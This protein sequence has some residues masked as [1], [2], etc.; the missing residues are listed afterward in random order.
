L[1]FESIR[2]PQEKISPHVSRITAILLDRLSDS[3]QKIADSAELSILSM[4]SSSCTDNASIIRAATKRIRSK[5]SKGG[6]TVKARLNFLENLAAEFGMG[7]GWKRMIDF[8]VS[9]DIF[10]H[11]DGGV[12]DAVKS[13]IVTLMA[14]SNT[15][16]IPSIRVANVSLVFLMGCTFVINQSIESSFLTLMHIHTRFMVRS[17][18]WTH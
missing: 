14:V 11:K 8:V 6:R 4:V 15:L 5:E 18:F 1:Q 9:N 3:K 17:A 13:F 2:L 12:R 10:D 16:L 7:L